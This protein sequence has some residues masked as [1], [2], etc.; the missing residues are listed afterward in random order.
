MRELAVIGFVALFFGLL[1][2]HATGHFG[3]FSVVNGALGAAALL[4]SGA[5]GARRL[6]ALSGPH[7]RRAVFR[8]LLGVVGAMLAAVTLERVASVADLRFDWTFERRYELAPATRQA[9]AAL[10][11]PLE[12]LLFYDP[13]DPRIRRTRM[14]LDTL[15]PHGDVVLRALEVDR[16]PAE[17]DTYGVRTSNSLVLRLGDAFELVERPTEGALYEALCRLQSIRAGVIALLRG[18]GQGDPER[19]DGVGYTGLVEALITEGYEVRSF[20]TAALDELPDDVDAVLSIAPKRR[21]RDTAL[22]A[23]RR[24]LARGGSLVA[25]LEPGVESGVEEILAEYGM[26]SPPALL[27]DPASG[28]VAEEARGLAPVARHYEEHPITTGL[29]RNRMTFFAGARS[30]VLRKPR[31]EDELRAVVRAGPD[32]WLSEDLSLLERRAGAIEPAGAHRDYH[33]IAVAGR[34]PR[35]GSETRILAFGDSDFA[36]NRHLRTLYNLDLALNGIHWTLK[37]E[38]AIALRPKLRTVVQFPLPMS[39]SLQM[40]YGVGLVVPELLLIAGGIIWLRRRAA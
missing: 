2:F 22:A 39:D 19:S 30:F 24:Y 37:R 36:S 23:L 7:W 16:A 35:D 17:M 3:V 20:V 5:A 10:G 6:R 32:S 4:V 29:D 12:I 38:P 34:Y 1:S 11:Q 40:L 8:G 25:L 31:V 18:E 13:L 14:L 9:L 15:A 28:A 27:V 26:H 33:P 21:L